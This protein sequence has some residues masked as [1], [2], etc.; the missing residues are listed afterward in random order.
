[1]RKLS[2]IVG[3]ASFIQFGAADISKG[4]KGSFWKSRDRIAFWFGSGEVCGQR[5]LRELVNILRFCPEEPGT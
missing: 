4:G 3:E 5:L 2:Q 1:L